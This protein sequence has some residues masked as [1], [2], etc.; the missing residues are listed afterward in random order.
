MTGWIPSRRRQ[1]D[2]SECV[3]PSLAETMQVRLLIVGALFRPRAMKSSFV[4]WSRPE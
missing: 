4:G 1:P 2:P 3:P